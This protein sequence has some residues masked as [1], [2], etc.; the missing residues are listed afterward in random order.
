MWR[1]LSRGVRTLLNGGGADRGVDDEVQHF[2]DE[3]AAE[4]EAGGMRP[5]EARRS[6]RLRVG[7]ALAIR[8][9]VRASGWE[10]MVETIAADL[11]YGVRRLVGHPGFTVVTIAT[12]ALGIG[13][14]T[15]M[16]SV[17]GPVLVRTLPFPHSDRIHA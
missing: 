12:L 8:E 10:H 15:A 9:E 2:L 6:A 3:A 4:Y 13:S 14:V 11:R 1:H 7:N 16:L 17:A 5:A